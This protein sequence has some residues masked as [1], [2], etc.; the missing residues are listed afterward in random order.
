MEAMLSW[1]GISGTMPCPPF[2]P[3]SSNPPPS[4]T[5]AASHVRGHSSQQPAMSHTQRRAGPPSKKVRMH[6]PSYVP[7]TFSSRFIPT[8]QTP[9]ETT[10][11]N[12]VASHYLRY[13]ALTERSNR[14]VSS[15]RTL[16]QAKRREPRSGPEPSAEAGTGAKRRGRNR[17]PGPES[18][19]GAKSRHRG[20]SRSRNLQP[21]PQW[22]PGAHPKARQPP[23]GEAKGLTGTQCRAGGTGSP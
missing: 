1:Q 7:K 21:R 14:S 18:E 8:R 23:G 22:K 12:T 6:H 9:T 13:P 10:P 20:E 19:R 15:K 3:E 2:P 11:E 4:L 17:P 16:C 5:T